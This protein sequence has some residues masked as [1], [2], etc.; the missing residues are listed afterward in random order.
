MRLEAALNMGQEVMMKPEDIE[1][2]K[3]ANTIAAGA[4]HPETNKI[5]P[6]YMRLSGFVVFNTPI[7]LLILF[8]RSQT[9]IFNAGMQWANQ[10]YNA[11]M[12]Y[13][14]RNASTP[15]TNVELAKGYCGAVVASC[16]IALASRTYFAR[17][18]STLKG[19]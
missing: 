1:D 10:T 19:P 4:V 18:L 14:N 7:L 13:G 11:G 6:F 17:Q 5:I 2:L 15:Y 12:N 9:P 8:T 16:G 3:R